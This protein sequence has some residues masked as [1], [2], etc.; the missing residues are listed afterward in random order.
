MTLMA[1]EQVSALYSGAY[2]DGN[3]TYLLGKLSMGALILHVKAY[4]RKSKAIHAEQ[5][6]GRAAALSPDSPTKQGRDSVQ[7]C[8]RA[9]GA[10]AASRP[11]VGPRRCEGGERSQLTMA[12][13][14]R[15]KATWPPD[16]T[17]SAMVSAT[18][19]SAFDANFLSVYLATVELG[20]EIKSGIEPEP[21]IKSEI[22]SETK[23]GIEPEPSSTAASAVAS[24]HVMS[25]VRKGRTSRTV[26]NTATKLWEDDHP[27]ANPRGQA[28]VN[29]S[30]AVNANPRG[31]AAVNASLAVNSSPRGQ[32]ARMAEDVL[33]AR[34]QILESRRAELEQRIRERE[35]VSRAAGAGARPK[36]Q[37]GWK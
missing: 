28:A 26:S 25:S 3:A 5:E 27:D 19:S 8:G 15:P 11:S 20:S 17:V 31:Q 32:A 13:V 34:R 33:A 21:E 24:A 6:R 35:A 16:T 36:G 18:E 12:P 30:L 23:S 7:L 9:G 2:P 10:A 1:V 29:A 14:G 22:K 37:G 4:L